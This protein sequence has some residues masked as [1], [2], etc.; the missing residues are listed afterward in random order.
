[1]LGAGC[2]RKLLFL[3]VYLSFKCIT[4]ILIYS[5]P[6]YLQITC[7]LYNINHVSSDG[8]NGIQAVDFIA[9]AIHRKYRNDDNSFYKLI[10]DKIDLALDSRKQI[11]KKRIK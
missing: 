1:L 3:G 9:G 6:S 8:N 7:P 10:K 4:I 2:G 11:F 5:H